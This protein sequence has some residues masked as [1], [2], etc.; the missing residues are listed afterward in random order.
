MGL[1]DSILRVVLLFKLSPYRRGREAVLQLHLRRPRD[2]AP[3][4]PA[5]L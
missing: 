3:L 1:A 5:V 2:P 4:Y